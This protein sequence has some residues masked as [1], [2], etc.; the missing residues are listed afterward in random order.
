VEHR[1]WSVSSEWIMQAGTQVASPGNS[2]IPQGHMYSESEAREKI[3]SFPPSL[4]PSDPAGLHGARTLMQ[5]STAPSALYTI[6]AAGTTFSPSN[7]PGGSSILNC[8]ASPT[9]LL[10]KYVEIED[11]LIVHSR[12]ARG[13]DHYQGS[14]L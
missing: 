2:A 10:I 11:R 6:S 8:G 4:G 7:L 12:R 5:S 9:A 1:K 14:G 3:I 13:Q